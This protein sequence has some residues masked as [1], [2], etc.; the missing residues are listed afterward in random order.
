[1]TSYLRRRRRWQ[2]REAAQRLQ[3]KLRA[4]I[5]HRR[6][7]RR[8]QSAAIPLSLLGISSC[9]LCLLSWGGEATRGTQHTDDG[10][11]SR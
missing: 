10:G 1:M 6:Q 5:W 11:C 7:Q 8:R 9:Q 2:T 4:R 3:V